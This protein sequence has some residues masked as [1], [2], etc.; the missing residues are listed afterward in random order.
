M[1]GLETGRNGRTLKRT[2]KRVAMSS[3]ILL[4]IGIATS[5]SVTASADTLG[6]PS[7][8]I[9]LVPI[10]TSYEDPDTGQI[11]S[12]LA[13]SESTV[14][15]YGQEGSTQPSLEVRVPP[16]SWRP[17]TATGAELAFYHIPAE[18]SGSGGATWLSEWSDYKAAPAPTGFCETG[19]SSGGAAVSSSS[20]GPSPAVTTCPN[21]SFNWEGTVVCGSNYT[22]S[23]ASVVMDSYAY[24]PG[25]NPS[26]HSSWVGLGGATGASNGLVQNGVNQIG[27][28]NQDTFFVEAIDVTNNYDTTEVVPNGFPTPNARDVI[29]L[30][31]T[32]NAAANY[33]YGEVLWGFHDMTSGFDQQIIGL[34]FNDART[35]AVFYPYQAYDGSYAEAIDERDTVSGPGGVPYYTQLRTFGSSTWNLDQVGQYGGGLVPWRTQQYHAGMTMQ[36]TQTGGAFG[37]LATI[38]APAGDNT[39]FTGT[40][41]NCG[42]YKQSGT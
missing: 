10:S 17:T 5:R 37:N 22:E 6:Q 20:T 32:Y 39:D 36:D 26:S 38:T 8:C 24:C 21:S 40:W 31:T 23:Y 42:T 27:Y 16:S 15:D 9:P 7:S 3:V 18:P 11:S 12:L 13:S 4:G 14:V 1:T 29:H 33:P 34:S 25:T 35:K 28:P 30:S 2:G 19:I 41:V